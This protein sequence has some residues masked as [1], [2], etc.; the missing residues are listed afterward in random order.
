MKSKNNLIWKIAGEA[1]FGIKSA[2]MMFGKIFMRAGYE[3][4]DFTE[5]PSLIRGGHNTYQLVVD[6]KP[7]N[8]VFKKVDILV[9]LN[10]NTIKYNLVDMNKDGAFIYDSDKVKVSSAI[11]SNNNI[12]GI[13]IP[14]T[15][16]AKEAGG[17]LMRN[18]VALG[19]TMYLVGQPLT[20]ANKIVRETFSKKGKKIVDNNI[21]ALKAG[22]DFV[23][24]NME[25]E[26]MCKLPSLKAKDNI[27]IT[28]NESLALG[29]VAGGLG[30]YAAYPMTPSSSILHYLAKIAAK[31]GLVVKHAEDEISV[32]NMALGASHMGA[33]S[34]V[35]TSGGGFALMTETLGLVGLTETPLVMINVQRGGPATG[36]PTWTEQA[37]LQFMLHAA[38][39]DFPRIVMAPGDAGEA[40]EMGHQALNWADMYQLPVL[41]LSD[42]LIGEGNTTVPRFN[43]K[44]VKINRGKILTQAQLNKIKEYGRYKVTQDGISPR[45]LPGMK[46]GLF[47]ANSDEHDAY[48]FSNEDS[49]NRIDQ[50]DKRYRKLDEFRKI[51]PKPL[52]YGNPKAKKTVVFWGSNKGVVLDSYVALP[53]K[54]KSKIRIMQY[55]YLWPFDG[56]FTKQIL[57]S[58]KDILLIENNP[59][60][61]LANLI[62]QETGIMI[63]NKLLK[64]DGRPFFREEI[65]SALKKF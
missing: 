45:A 42:K 38:Q 34:M 19:T 15:T 41:I 61:Q 17:E 51:M 3:I 25:D 43:S 6:I 47:I 64:Y 32:A 65:I 44:N 12:Q 30:F 40:F 24:A 21:K 56:E 9:A 35:A 50:V 11:L 31:T 14:L 53:D 52:I 39:G 28:A 7:V 27:L 29:A 57:N 37:D 23:K 58:S 59:N 46:G 5:Y 4:F 13:A 16:I 22:Y 18:V 8:S 1:G 62:A 55:Q 60:G 63:K 10:Q 54:I 2:G 20:I 26:F 33:R 36:L 48:G 49:Q